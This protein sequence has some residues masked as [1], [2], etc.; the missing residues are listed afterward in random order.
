MPALSLERFPPLQECPIICS[1]VATIAGQL[2]RLTIAQIGGGRIQEG[3]R[4]SRRAFTGVSLPVISSV[5]HLYFHLYNLELLP[6]S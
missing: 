1:P 2:V 5:F 3:G 6:Q 4:R